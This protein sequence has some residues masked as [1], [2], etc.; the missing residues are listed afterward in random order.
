MKKIT[1]ADWDRLIK[2]ERYDEDVV[3]AKKIFWNKTDKEIMESFESGTGYIERCD[4]LRYMPDELFNYYYHYFPTFVMEGTYDYLE[5]PSVAGSFM[6][7]LGEK[8][9]SHSFY[10]A[11]LLALANKVLDFILDNIDKFNTDPDI[12]GDFLPKIETLKADIKIYPITR[13]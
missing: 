9:K 8:L 4:E 5:D 2:E 11:E 1:E 12:F 6:Q 7:L 13:H 10:Y 3:Y